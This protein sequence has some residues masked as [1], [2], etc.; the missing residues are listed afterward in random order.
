MAKGRLDDDLAQQMHALA[1]V[2]AWPWE[3][4]LA[5]SADAVLRQTA[6]I[7]VHQGPT[8]WCLDLHVPPPGVEGFRGACD[9][10][11]ATRAGGGTR[12]TR[13]PLGRAALAVPVLSTC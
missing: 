6:A 1:A 10:A 3:V 8:V 12:G 11:S 7:V 2:H 9:D 5:P 4:R 13:E